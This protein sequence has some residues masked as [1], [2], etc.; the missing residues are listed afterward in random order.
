MSRPVALALA[1][2]GESL[3][4]VMPSGRNP[5]F[6]VGAI[7]F[8]V[9]WL[10]SVVVGIGFAVRA[11]PDSRTG[12]VWVA[13]LL[14]TIALTVLLD[15]LAV[16]IIWLA[17][18]ALAGSETL[19]LTATQIRVRRKAVGIT[20]RVSAKRGHFDRVTRLD[21]RDAAGR[22]PHPQVEVSGAYSR[23]RVGAGL[24]RDEAG[25]LVERADAFLK[26]SEPE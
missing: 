5:W 10:V 23:V 22:V 11:I 9:P 24:T 16:A 20:M 15:V 13:V 2:D 26:T 1:E 4:A 8:G 17:L 3:R 6:I 21:V 19:E 25:V 7:V 14:G 12:L 18:Y